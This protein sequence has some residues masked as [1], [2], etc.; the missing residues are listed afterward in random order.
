MWLARLDAGVGKNGGMLKGVKGE[1]DQ[2][3]K[4]FYREAAVGG[5]GDAWKVLLDGKVLKTPEKADL[6]LP[7]EAMARAL[8]AEWNAQEER[9][10]I[11]SMFITRTANVAID[12]TPHARS[13]MADEAA[14]YV[15]TDLVC[16]LA[17]SPEELC[18]RQEQA[19]TP[20]RDWA[21]SS[22][23][24]ELL[25]TDGLAPVEQPA[26]TIEAVRAHASA[27]DDWRLTGLVFGVGLCGS[28]VLGLA[29]EQS[30]LDARQAFELSRIDEAFQ[31]S[32]W[33]EEAEAMRVTERRRAEAVALDLWF[34]ALDGGSG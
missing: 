13:E 14:R 30:H 17:D 11:A 20:L 27:L 22:M 28:A 6:L 1:I 12:R 2:R 8:A 31:E 33:G 16:Y 7:C 26:A 32:I 18:E 9:I 23:G 24:L 10:D 19:W 34:E 3:P 15:S 21:K 29:I 5:A 25:T 4:R